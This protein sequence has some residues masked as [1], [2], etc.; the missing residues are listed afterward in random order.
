MT[1]HLFHLS[2]TELLFVLSCLFWLNVEAQ[3]EQDYLSEIIY[4]A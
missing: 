4:V 3:K 2:A 1:D